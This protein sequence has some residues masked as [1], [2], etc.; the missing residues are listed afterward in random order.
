MVQNTF[1]EDLYSPHYDMDIYESY[2]LV[3]L[4]YY[5]YYYYYYYGLTGWGNAPSHIII[6]IIIM[7][8]QDGEMHPH[9]LSTLERYGSHKV[10]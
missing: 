1:W 8:W 4:Y 5:Y 2:F 6:I 7:V 9:T 10:C 3:A